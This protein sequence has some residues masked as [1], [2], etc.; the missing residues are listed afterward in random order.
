MAI[1]K[2]IA[3]EVLVNEKVEDNDSFQINVALLFV[4]L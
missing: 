4:Y 2:I 1:E 3:L